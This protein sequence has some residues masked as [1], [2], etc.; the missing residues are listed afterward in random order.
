MHTVF[1]HIVSKELSPKYENIATES[2]AFI[3]QNSESARNGMMKLLR[4]VTPDMPDLQF[5]T[6]ST[7]HVDKRNIRPDML[8]YHE[9]GTR[10]FIENKFEAGLTNNQPESYLKQLVGYTQPSI[11]LVVVPEVREESMWG[12]LNRK[13]KGAGISVTN[14]DTSSCSI[15]YSIKTEKGP[16]LA[17]TSWKRLLSALGDEVAEDP[18]AKSDLIQLQSLC[19]AADR[20]AFIPISPVVVSD[21]RTPAF[22]LQLN[23]IVQGSI[24]KAANDGALNITNV[25]PQADFNRIGRYANIST[26][27]DIGGW[28]GI[29]FPLWKEYGRTPL[30]FVF[31]GSYWGRSREVWPLL[32]P[33]AEKEGVFTKFVGE[34]F[35]IAIDL[36]F[37]EDK[38]QVVR[39]VVEQL[40][41]I[42]DILN[43]L[44]LKL[45]KTE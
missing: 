27:R 20:M 34:D 19:D 15:V 7:E 23:S 5:R 33:K 30:W 2:L 32:G 4:G 1:S 37:G 21:Q 24:D 25:K 45:V 8:G 11:L 39:T 22:I 6:Q 16:I 43:E 26:R 38:D 13:L 31:N 44:P 28:F 36:A 12:E 3:L 9:H 17:L 41:W 35:A 10:V 18:S 29:N 40:K 42:A 14:L